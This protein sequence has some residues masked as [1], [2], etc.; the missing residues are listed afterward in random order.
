MAATRWPAGQPLPDWIFTLEELITHLQTVGS[1]NQSTPAVPD[2]MPFGELVAAVVDYA[3][4]QLPETLVPTEAIRP[5]MDALASQLEGLLS[6]VLYVEFKSFLNHHAPELIDADPSEFE[7]LPQSHYSQFIDAMFEHGFENLC[8]EYP[9]LARNLVYAVTHWN[10]ALIELCQ[11]I[12]TDQDDLRKQFDVN[13]AVTE[14][15]PLAEDAH[16]EGQLPVRVQ[17]ETG[18]V[19]YKPRPVDGGVLFYEIV[20]RIEAHLSTAAIRV[21]TYLQRE[22]YGW[23]EPVEYQTLSESAAAQQY[24]ER[25]GVLLSVAY[26]LNFTDI[27]LENVI[28]SGDTPTII[29]CETIFHPFMTPTERP[30]QSEIPAM[31]DKLVLLTALLPWSSGDPRGPDKEGLA[32][33]MAGLGSDSNQTKITSRTRPE[34]QNV[35][36]DLMSVDGKPVEVGLDTNTPS[37][38][39]QDYPP[40]LY[41]NSLV[42]GFKQT[43][44]TIRELHDAGQFTTEIV[45]HDSLAEVETRLVYRPTAEYINLR[46]SAVGREPLQDGVQ[47]SVELESLAAPFFDDRL[48]TNR[49]WPLYE[50]ERRA[51]A[52]LDVP[53]FTS[54]ADGTRVYHDGEYLGVDTDLSGYDRYRR[55][56]DEMGPADRHKQQ[57]MIKQAF[58]PSAALD[59]DP[60]PQATPPTGDQLE[61]EAA[62]LFEAASDA[63]INIGNKPSWVSITP[64]FDGINL[65]PADSSVYWGRGGIALAAAALAETTGKDRYRTAVEEILEPVVESVRAEHS[66]LK[67]GGIRGIGSVVYTFSVIAD[68]FDMDDYR[69]VA[70]EASRFVSKKRLAADETFDVMEGAA[71]T[72]LGLSAY[73]DRF[74]N[75]TVLDRAKDCGDH[76]LQARTSVDGYDVWLTSDDGTVTTGFAHGTSGIAYALSRLA[77]VTSGSKYAEG[78]QEALAFESTLFADHRNNWP[79]SSAGAEYVDRWC[80]GRTGMALA[81]TGIAKHLNE[82][83]RLNEASTA[84]AATAVAEPAHLDSICCGNAGRVEAMLVGARHTDLNHHHATALAGRLLAR[85]D[86]DGVLSLPGHSKQFVNPTFFDGV[87]GVAYTLCRLQDPDTLPCV[88]LL[89]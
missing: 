61:I 74:G 81:R 88:L 4:D 80:H 2:E 52:R 70:L 24:Y 48:E 30:F 20:N 5:M 64:S 57:W 44:K 13:G 66:N 10:G 72:A 38:G 67:L 46:R 22:H 63:R 47:L 21:P 82:E 51:L 56:L 43:Y 16:A 28:A 36:T 84:L 79:K 14:L 42:D 78:A 29:D 58:D 27:Q 19:I 53:R 9:V 25:A 41:I 45:D 69:Q 37:K 3:R 7:E 17:F 12:V 33:S 55:R 85:R 34:I 89:E 75:S 23:M 83:K 73:Y 32:A 59:D 65:Y 35:N 1:N 50:A 11:R 6:R 76:L 71:G 8:V 54:H 77:D 40:E 87:A 62:D 26:V 68:L 15:N 86:R 31:L 49:Y 60:A 18:S 39:E